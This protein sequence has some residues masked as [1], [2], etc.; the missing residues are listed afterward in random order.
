MTRTKGFQAALIL[1]IA[2]AISDLF[3]EPLIWA[4]DDTPGGYY[5]VGGGSDL[6]KDHPGVEIDLYR[7]VAEKLGIDIQIKRFPWKRCLSLIEQ[8]RVD[9]I[10]PAS[11]K[12]KRMKIGVYPMSGKTLDLNRKTRDTA[13]FLY[14]LKSNNIT[15]DGNTFS[16]VNGSIGVPRGWA[17]VD[18]LKKKGVQII[19]LDI[20]KRTPMLLTHKR[21]QGFVC[22]ETVFDHYI[23]NNPSVFSNIV[24]VHPFVKDKPYFLI[25]SHK[26]VNKFPK[27]SE[28]I[29][30]TLHDIKQTKWY[31]D[32]VDKYIEML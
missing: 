13:Y 20:N 14:K 26:F 1:I 8:N 30:D 18:E 9:G 6:D 31:S 24:K 32:L 16:N 3:A 2:L 7:R 15:W 23:D 21:L 29:W 4:T 5:I 11:F 17:I 19:E 25:F 22:L 28:K 10:F 27:L 12:S